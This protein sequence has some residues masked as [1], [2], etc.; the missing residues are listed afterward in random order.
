MKTL[1]LSL[2]GGVLGFIFCFFQ[3]HDLCRH[4]EMLNQGVPLSMNSRQDA[5]EPQPKSW[6]YIFKWKF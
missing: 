1:C 3:M 5:P 6:I 2:P 4:L